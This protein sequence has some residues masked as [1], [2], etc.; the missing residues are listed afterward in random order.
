MLQLLP[1]WCTAIDKEKAKA[2]LVET[3]CVPFLTFDLNYSSTCWEVTQSCPDRAVTRTF[4]NHFAT[5]RQL[6][7]DKAPINHRLI[8]DQSQIGCRYIPALFMVKAIATLSET[9]SKDSSQPIWSGDRSETF[10]NF[11]KTFP[12]PLRPLCDC[13]FVWS[14]SSCIAVARYVWLGF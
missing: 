4:G 8:A 6:V 3:F 1:Q 10:G 11:S 2:V 14:Q 5:D 13:Q 7:G 9:L 12:R